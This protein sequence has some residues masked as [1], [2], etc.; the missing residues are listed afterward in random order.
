GRVEV[1]L[2]PAIVV[3]VEGDVRHQGLDKEIKPDVYEPYRQFPP[4]HFT[5]AVRT[6]V[7]PHSLAAATRAAAHA[8]DSDQPLYEVM[9]MEERLSDSVAARRFTLLLLGVFALLALALAAVG[10]GG[11]GYF[12]VT[13]VTHQGGDPM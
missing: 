7:E 12:G 13:P 1:R 3:A 5:L 8:V 11:V 9:T 6:A 10:V 2:N 4:G